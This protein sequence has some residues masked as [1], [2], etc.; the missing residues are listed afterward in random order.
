MR[1]ALSSLCL[2]LLGCDDARGRVAGEDVVLR[3]AIFATDPDRFGEVGALGV[4]A[5]GAGGCA[6]YEALDLA[7]AEAEADGAYAEAWSAEMPGDFW[8]LRL[9]VLEGEEGL[10]DTLTLQPADAA[11]V[12]AGQARIELVHYLDTPAE[13]SWS[14]GDGWAELW[15]NEGGTLALEYD[16][17][18]ELSGEL[19]AS[20]VDG[21]GQDQ[22][23]LHLRIHAEPCDLGAVFEPDFRRW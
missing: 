2:I 19:T 16:N 3:Q 15:V 5:S 23:E 1:R 12:E 21:I 6:Q 7:L 18:G 11:P 17:K 14:G 20:F 8:E 13:G 10:G 22:G 4:L 9:L